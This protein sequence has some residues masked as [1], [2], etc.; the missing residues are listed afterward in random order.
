ME[1]A[2]VL[3][4]TFACGADHCSIV[5]CGYFKVPLSSPDFPPSL[6][7]PVLS[8]ITPAMTASF[9]ATA[10]GQWTSKCNLLKTLIGY[11]CC[12]DRPS[13]GL[14]HSPA[15]LLF[16]LTL[17]LSRMQVAIVVDMTADGQW[18]VFT[19]CNFKNFVLIFCVKLSRRLF[20]CVKFLCSN[21]IVGCSNPR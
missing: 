2:T 18:N 5:T 15:H 17:T 6:A 4:Y 8:C 16:P 3:A 10:N 7:H 20:S 19:Y 11:V 1:S 12:Y 14:L 13:L 9:M 21:I